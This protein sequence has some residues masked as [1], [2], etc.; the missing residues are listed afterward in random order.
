MK[1][2]LLILLFSVFLITPCYAEPYDSAELH[3]ALPED[4]SELLEGAELSPQESLGKIGDAFTDAVASG[5]GGAIKRALAVIAVAVICAALTVFSGSMPEYVSLGGCAAVAVISVNEV[6]SFITSAQQ[7]IDILSGFSKTLLPAMC[8]A[9]AACGTLGTATAKYA[10]SVLFMDAFVSFSQ[11]IILPIIYAFLAVSISAAA[12]GS[13][14]LSDIAAALKR[15]C[16]LFMTA[17]ALGFT[18]YIS[19]SSVVAS[20]GD[21]VASKLTKTAISTVLPVVGSMISDAASTVVAGAQVMRNS[22]GVFGMLALLAVCAVPFAAMGL[23]YLSYK[24]AAFAVRAFGC[25]KLS[26]L[27]SGIAAAIGMILGLAGCC[28]II[29]FVSM[30]ISIKA[31]S[32]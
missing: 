24:L 14:P 10:A 1:K 26:E 31:V 28:A 21:A 29:L 2:L 27:T 4:T 17:A 19:I 23:N 8:A 3:D 7:V 5:L 22:V 16:S 12:F 15:L 6:S 30:A 20:G 13:R 11:G 32:I 25:D 9:S 18:V